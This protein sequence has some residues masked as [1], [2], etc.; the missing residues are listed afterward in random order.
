[1]SMKLIKAAE[2]G[3]IAAIKK[4]L[5]AGDD[6]RFVQKGTNFNALIMAVYAEQVDAV[7]CLLDHSSPL[8]DISTTG[9]TALG[10]AASHGDLPVL[11][12]LKDAGA[13]LEKHQDKTGR[14]PY[15]V[16]LDYGKWDA[17]RWFWTAG[18]DLQCRDSLGMNAHDI[19]VGTTRDVPADVMERA[20]K[21]AASAPQ[22]EV[23]VSPL[24]DVQAWPDEPIAQLHWPTDFPPLAPQFDNE[25]VG[26]GLEKA[27]FD[28]S[29]HTAIAE[30]LAPALASPTAAVRSWVWTQSRW[31]K[32]S[33]EVMEPLEGDDLPPYIAEYWRQMVGGATIRQAFVHPRARRAQSQGLPN[34]VRIRGELLLQYVQPA[35][36]NK[37]EVAV[38][39]R[40]AVPEGSSKAEELRALERMDE[41]R[42][43]VVNSGKKGQP[44]AWRVDALKMRSFGYKDW[45]SETL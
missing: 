23:S 6:I 42:F 20:A 36:T 15:L 27:C 9:W 43:I 33:R 4:R 13:D 14:T 24:D 28:E 16:A 30:A 29:F 18:V 5:A 41:L 12:M 45:Y 1:M 21:E 3:N 39:A 7:G 31:E 37:V 44:Q 26:K 2:E 8:D 38:L 35:G 22:P 32:E 17:V 11:Q 19:L 10:W 34:G 40:P 25:A